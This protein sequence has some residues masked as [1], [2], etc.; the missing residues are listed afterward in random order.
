MSEIEDAQQLFF[1]CQQ[2]F[3]QWVTISLACGS[4]WFVIMAYFGHTRLLLDS[5]I[6]SFCHLGSMVDT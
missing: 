1:G 6:L 2:Y 4:L 3:L 5:L